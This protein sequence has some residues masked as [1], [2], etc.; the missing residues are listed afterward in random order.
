MIDA[1]VVATAVVLVGYVVFGVT[2]FGA[3][4]LTVPLLAHFLPLTFVLSLAAI[5]DLASGLALGIHTRRQ[6]NRR[7]LLVLIPFT[8]IGLV[9]GVTLLVNL[10]RAVALRA[11]GVFVCA[12]A[13]YATIRRDGRQRVGW[14][15]AVPAGVAGGVFG[16]LFGAGGPPYVMYLTGRVTDPARQRATISQMVILNVGFRVV[17]FALTGLLFGRD[18]WT[19]VA[20]LLPVAWAGV[21]LGNRLQAKLPSTMLA[22]IVAAA[23]CVTGVSLIVRTL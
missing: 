14:G 8:L 7:E 23:L 19:W 5:L 15:W 21:W 13:L 4:P 9:L 1:L 16:A 20:V 3:S 2:G 10:P 17:A 18:L 6:A 11:L 12:Y 22:R